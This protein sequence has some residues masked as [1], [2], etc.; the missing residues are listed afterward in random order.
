MV[1]KI[2]AVLV[3]LY[4]FM[5]QGMAA[6][7]VN[8]ATSA[9]LDAIKGIG[10][11][12]AGRIIEERKKGNFKDWDDFINR[13]QGVGDKN[14]A[15]FSEQG[16]TVNNAAFKGAPAKP[17]ADTKPKETAKSKAADSSSKSTTASVEK[18]SKKADK[19]SSAP[20]A[21]P[22]ATASGKAKSKS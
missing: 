11:A 9:E 14:A 10:P 16:L 22:S 13:V 6:V 7:D 20:A 2:L 4:V 15:K 3:F 19:K 1:K 17:G 5:A 18:V 8:K 21:K 12:I